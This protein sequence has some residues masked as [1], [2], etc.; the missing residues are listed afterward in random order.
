[1]TIRSRPAPSTAVFPYTTLFRSNLAV[2]TITLNASDSFTNVATQKT[3]V[4]T[5]NGLPV[6]TVPGP[7]TVGVGKAL[8][9]SGVSLSE[10]GD[11]AAETYTATL[12]VT[13]LLL[14]ATEAG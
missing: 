11:N 10:T 7:V 3:I 4:V 14:S 6:I 2:D 9:I 12:L 8:A 5:V 1:M 13:T